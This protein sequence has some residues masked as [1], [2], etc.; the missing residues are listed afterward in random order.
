MSRTHVCTDS[1]CCTG[2]VKPC[3]VNVHES[4]S[5]ATMSLFT[6]TQNG[7]SCTSRKKER[8]TQQRPRC[9]QPLPRPL[10]ESQQQPARGNQE[11]PRPVNKL[12]QPC[13]VAS[14]THFGLRY[15]KRGHTVAEGKSSGQRPSRCSCARR[16][17][18]TTPSRIL[19]EPTESSMSINLS[20]WHEFCAFFFFHGQALRASARKY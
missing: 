13:S 1:F 11:K 6:H 20:S 8:E 2:G 15:P 19:K 9:A 17:H 10:S 7:I 3:A 14:N 12:A 18:H 4:V 5:S 16:L